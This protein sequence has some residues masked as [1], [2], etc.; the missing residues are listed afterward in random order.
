[1]NSNYYETE[2]LNLAAYLIA[3]GICRLEGVENLNAWKKKFII[4]PYP[5]D[6]QIAG[7]YNGVGNVSGLA[8]CNQLR[9]LK[10]AVKV[11][12]VDHVG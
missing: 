10:A 8:L 5:T 7:F 12:G 4:H 3:A 6:N 1:M 2:D 9:S 11:K